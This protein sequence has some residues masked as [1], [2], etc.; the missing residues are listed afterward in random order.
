[1]DLSM[2]L[3][4]VADVLDHVSSNSDAIVEIA[5]SL[6]SSGGDRLVEVSVSVSG[7]NPGTLTIRSVPMDS[8]PVQGSAVLLRTA[9]IRGEDLLARRLAHDAREL[10]SFYLSVSRMRDKYGGVI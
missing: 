10:A 3:S 7:L 4:R 8:N 5:S 2:D 1:M 6:E 9:K